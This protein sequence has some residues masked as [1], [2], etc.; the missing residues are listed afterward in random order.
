MKIQNF[1]YGAQTDDR[2]EGLAQS[3]MLSQHTQKWRYK[4]Q[5]WEP[6]H[7]ISHNVVCATSK[8]SD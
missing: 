6:V 7:E 3:K 4:T 1:F 5:S 2:T 8:A